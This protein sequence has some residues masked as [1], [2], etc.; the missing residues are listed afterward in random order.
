MTSPEERYERW[1][2]TATVAWA[3]IGVLILVGVALWAIGKISEA[4]VPFII[5][6][7]IV[8][9]LNW[10]VRALV[11]RGVRRSIAVLI[12]FVVMFLVSF[13]MGKKLGEDILLGEPADGKHPSVVDIADTNSTEVAQR[14]HVAAEPGDL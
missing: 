14:Q 4:L 1:R 2:T 6:F 10:P 3:S 7:L 12:C 11:K 8:F 13:Y 5:A 9:L